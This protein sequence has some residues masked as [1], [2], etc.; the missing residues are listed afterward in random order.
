MNSSGDFLDIKTV[1]LHPFNAVE[2][3]VA[4][5]IS[6]V[7]LTTTWSFAALDSIDGDSAGTLDRQFPLFFC[8]ACCGC[9]HLVP[10]LPSF[11]TN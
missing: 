9:C 8:L 4:Q 10:H 3:A 11:Q 7:N 1:H 2:L 6:G 5:E